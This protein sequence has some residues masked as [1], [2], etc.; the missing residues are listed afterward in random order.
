MLVKPQDNAITRYLFRPISSRLSRVLVKTP[1]TATQVS[2]VVAVLVALGCWLTL[3]PRPSMMIAGAL[4][5]L[6]A[7]Y[8]D[9]CDGEI[10]KWS[11]SASG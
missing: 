11:W 8:L 2:L 10:A 3:D 9:C 5:I 6:G 1:I 7:T 4:T